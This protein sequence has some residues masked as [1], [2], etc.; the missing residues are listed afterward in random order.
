LKATPVEILK[1]FEILSSLS[2][3]E[4]DSLYSHMKIEEYSKGRPLFNEGESGDHMYIILS[5]AVSISVNTPD[6]KILEIAEITEGNFFGEMSIFDRAVRSATCSPKCETTVLSLGASDFFEFIK[7]KPLAGSIIMRKMLNITTKRLHKTGAFL[8]DMVTWGEAARTRAIS[9]DFTGLYNRRFLDEVL[10]N[11]ISESLS[12]RQPLSYA[13]IDL[14]HFG[15]LNNE[16]GQELGDKVILAVVDTFKRIFRKSDIITR[17]GGDEFIVLFPQTSSLSAF[18]ICKKMLEEIGNIDLVKK[19][20]GSMLKITASVGIASVP[21]H[22]DSA[23][24]LKDSAD[25]ALYMAKDAGRDTV[26]LWNDKEDN[27]V[28]TRMES[29]GA[30]NRIINNILKAISE[31]DDF[32][33]M[34]HKNPDEDCISSMIAISLLLNKFSK[35]VYLLIP[36]KINKNYQYLL[37]ICRFNTIEILYNDEKIP[38]GISTVFFMD[39]PK[40]E[41]RENFPDSDIIFKNSNILKIEIDHHLEADSAYIGDNNYTLVDEASSASE[42]VGLMAFKLK[43]KKELIEAFNIQ[44][45]FTR[46]F[47]LSVLT[48]IIG[49]SKM[50][51]YLKTRREKWFYSLFSSM[52]SEMLT[53]KTHKNSRNFSTMKEVFT[54][55]QQLTKHEDECFTLM[56]AQKVNFSTKIG[57]VIVKKDIVRQMAVIYDHETIISVARYSADSLAEYTHLLSLVVYYDDNEES[58]LIQF[59]IRRSHSYKTLDLRSILSFFKIKNGGG[60]PGAIGFRIPEP[61]IKNLEEYVKH[62]ISGIE[63]LMTDTISQ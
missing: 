4:L 15:K 2:N 20:D 12:N 24:L 10:E 36:R 34:G 6:G 14:D 63:K 31:H 32:L 57:T 21:D 22:A 42:L 18:T 11:R 3:S 19:S 5:G 13:M 9:D 38:K 8:S 41:M 25:K 40:P 29:I 35:T 23:S 50:G 48:G 49:D 62:L 53:K 44:D 30:R 28:K 60:H 58:N 43:N 7:N 46:N 54:E 52:F 61:E 1:S 37:N 56:M 39:T 27:P 59:R 33:V 45:I 26:V 47:V 16:F 51:K 55:L 17:Y